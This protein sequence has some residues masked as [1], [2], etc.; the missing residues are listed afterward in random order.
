MTFGTR[1]RV[2]LGTAVAAL[3]LVSS[4]LRPFKAAGTGTVTLTDDLAGHTFDA[5]TQG[6][7]TV[8]RP[9]RL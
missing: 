9:G 3:I 4:A 1:R 7:L 5:R 2:A 8:S 6:T